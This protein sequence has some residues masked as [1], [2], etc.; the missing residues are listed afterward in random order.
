MHRDIAFEVE[1]VAA[2]TAEDQERACD[3]WKADF[4]NCCP[5]EALG[6]KTSSQVYKP[7][8]TSYAGKKSSFCILNACWCVPS[9]AEDSSSTCTTMIP[10][11][12][13]LAGYPVAID[14]HSGPPHDLWLI[15]LLR[16]C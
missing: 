14:P 9:L 4:N 10:L 12:E 8:A 16:W 1:A 3:L 6:M 7:S 5:H 15:S 13:A 2:A 11:T